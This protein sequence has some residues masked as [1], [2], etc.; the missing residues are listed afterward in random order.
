MIWFAQSNF[1]V[2]CGK[3]TVPASPAANQAT[4][5]EAT[6]AATWPSAR[7]GG[8]STS[9]SGTRLSSSQAAANPSKTCEVD[10][11]DDEIRIVEEATK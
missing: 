6:A 10:W 7:A 3:E 9:Y 2:T 4:Y 5:P 11:T 8:E 1:E